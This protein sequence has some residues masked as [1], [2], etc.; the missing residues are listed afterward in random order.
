MASGLSS[1][2]EWIRAWEDIAASKRAGLD[3]LELQ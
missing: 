2:M 3:V 1:A